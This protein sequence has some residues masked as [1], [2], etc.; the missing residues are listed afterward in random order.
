[1]RAAFLLLAAAATLAASGAEGAVKPWF[2]NVVPTWNGTAAEFTV[3]EMIRQKETVGIDTFI[4]S[5]S[6]HPQTTPAKDL[7]PK[8]CGHYRR[9]REGVAGKGITLGVLVQS[10]LGHG[11]NGKVPLTE[12]TWQ[13][14]VL[15]TGEESPRFCTLDPGFRAYVYEAIR[16]IALEK[17]AFLL[18]D[19][20]TGIRNGECFCPLHLARINRALGKSYTREEMRK[21]YEERPVS[22]SEVVT[23]NRVLNETIVEFGRDAIRKAIDS[24]DPTLRCGICACW[25]GYWQMN[26]MVHALAGKTKPFMRVNDACYGDQQAF[27]LVHAVQG[28]RAVMYQVDDDVELIDEADTFPH[29]C[30]SESATMFHAHLTHAFLNGL[31][32]AKLWTAEFQEP[33]DTGSARRYEARLRDY[34]GFYA[35]LRQMV[36]DGLVWEGP[37]RP[38]VRPAPGYGG[39]PLRCVSGIYPDHWNPPLE[40]VYA[41]PV[42]YEGVEKGGLIVLREEDVVRLDD[43][44]VRQ[45]LAGRTLVDS[46]AARK[47]T[48]RGLAELLGVRAEEGGDDFHFTCEWSADGKHSLGYMWDETTSELKP[49]SDKATVRWSFCQGPRFPRPESFAPSVVRFENALGGRVVTLGW[50]LDVIYYKSFRPVRKQGLLEELDWLNGRPLDGVGLSGDQALVRMG[51]TAAGERIVAFTSLTYEVL[52]R[53]ELRFAT[54]PL[55]I[56]RLSPKGVWEPVSFSRMGAD[57]VAVDVRVDPLEPIVLKVHP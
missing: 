28:A 18:V 48:E 11:W 41:I 3:S 55:E 56:L 51:T 35:T 6:F 27:S 39:N 15:W 32:G 33:A 43:A 34:V 8:L 46:M 1:M 5:L 52:P 36:A 30:M 57:G 42:R 29:N 14:V 49:L 13:H 47:L 4:P 2:M 50:C 16:S 25:G 26:D 31:V 19:D 44:Q 40:A 12:E 38:L 23:M 20:D 21:I 7:I 45:V 10:L 53:L 9:L 17:P 54:M 24:V 37:S 22:D